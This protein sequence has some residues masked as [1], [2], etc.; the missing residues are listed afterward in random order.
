MWHVTHAHPGSPKDE[1]ILLKDHKRAEPDF[2]V[3]INKINK[4]I[5]TRPVKALNISFRI[6]MTN[7][8][9]ILMGQ[10]LSPTLRTLV[11]KCWEKKKIFVC[12]TTFFWNDAKFYV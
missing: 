12:K 6:Y 3:K 2:Y 11:S 8:A 5:R 4:K 9:T 7:N 10:T 1:V